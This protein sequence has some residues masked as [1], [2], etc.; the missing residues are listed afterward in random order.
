MTITS[1]WDTLKKSGFILCPHGECDSGPMTRVSVCSTP[2]LGTLCQLYYPAMWSQKNSFSK[3]LGYKT[4]LNKTSLN[5][6]RLW[7]I[8]CTCVK[9]QVWEPRTCGCQ[10]GKAVGPG[11]DGV[12]IAP[13][14]SQSPL[15]LRTQVE[16]NDA[17]QG[18]CCF[19]LIGCLG[20]FQLKAM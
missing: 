7:V 8:S 6:A 3:H 10:Q 14:H 20:D 17:A 16:S 9:T 18:W 19:I 4:Q 15:F 1:I 5:P 2:N 13:G 11:W 12:D